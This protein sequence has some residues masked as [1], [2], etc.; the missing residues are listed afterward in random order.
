M[1]SV[2][3]G[4]IIPPLVAQVVSKSSVHAQVIRFWRGI[5]VVLMCRSDVETA[6]T[7]SI[8]KVTWPSNTFI[9]PEM[10]YCRTVG[11]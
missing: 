4:I 7:E 9:Y 11:G 5:M 1:R 2:P 8:L 10:Q 6:Q 3:G